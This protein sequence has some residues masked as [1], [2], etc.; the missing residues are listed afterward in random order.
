MSSADPLTCSEC[1]AAPVPSVALD[2]RPRCALKQSEAPQTRFRAIASLL[3]GM[4]GL[5]Q[6][7][8]FLNAASAAVAQTIDF[9]NVPG[10][11]SP[12]DGMGISN[13]FLLKFGVSFSLEGGGF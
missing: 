2:H 11:P 8:L 13:Q 5:L 9:E 1:G 6:A 12:I 7:L 10:V 3:A 4:K